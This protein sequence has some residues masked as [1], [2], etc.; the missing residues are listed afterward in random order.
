MKRLFTIL[1][2]SLTVVYTCMAESAYKRKTTEIQ[3][4]YGYYFLYGKMPSNGIKS[5]PPAKQ[6]EVELYLAGMGIADLALAAYTLNNTLTQAQAVSALK[7]CLQ[8]LEEA[9]KLMT[10]EERAEAKRRE[11]ARKEWEAEEAARKAAKERRKYKDQRGKDFPVAKITYDIE[12]SLLRWEKKSEYEKSTEYMLR[13]QTKSDSVFEAICRQ[14][15]VTPSHINYSKKSYDADKEEYEIEVSVWSEGKW[16]GKGRELN[17][18]VRIQVSPDIAPKIRVPS[19]DSYPL[20]RGNLVVFG[21]NFITWESIVF[22]LYEGL[23]IDF[24]VQDYPNYISDIIISCD[25]MDITNPYLKGARYNFTRNRREYDA[26]TQARLDSLRIAAEEARYDSL[27]AYYFQVVTNANQQLLASPYNID[28][29]QFEIKEKTSGL[30]S[31]DSLYEASKRNLETMFLTKTSQWLDSMQQNVRQNYPEKYVEIYFMQNPEDRKRLSEMY[32][33]YRCKYTVEDFYRLNIYEEPLVPRSCREELYG[34]FGYLFENE[35]EFYSYYLQGD[36]ILESIVKDRQQKREIQ[37]L[38]REFEQF[39]ESEQEVASY[40]LQGGDSLVANVAQDRQLKREVTNWIESLDNTTAGL[41][42]CGALSSSSY[43]VSTFLIRLGALSTNP[44][45]SDA[46]HALIQHNKKM[47]KEFNKSGQLFTDEKAF[48]EAY[49]T[50]NYRKIRK[51]LEKQ[52][53]N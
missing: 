14:Y 37:L 19:V 49:I 40:Y 11:E 53:E 39:F 48:Y 26:K 10:S 41:N 42:L 38:Y 16:G 4:K 13:L 32:V 18:M 6:V 31:T 46:I 15:W 45:F 9:K 8:E 3:I 12:D 28:S 52:K 25:S 24:G 33:D 20:H 36:S 34:N 7:K 2:L 50:D 30:I 22:E 35:Q 17:F 1:F 51:T 47:Q 21:E 43:E 44:Y 27:Y 5:I 29:I 23:T